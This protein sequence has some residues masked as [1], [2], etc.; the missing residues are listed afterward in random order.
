MTKIKELISK[1][2]L[3]Y[4]VYLGLSI[5]VIGLTGLGY[6]SDNLLF[7]RFLG[8]INLLIAI[9][10]II[11]LGLVLLSFLLSQGWFAIYE[12]ENLKGLLRY[13][14]LATLFGLI[15][16]LV[17][18]LTVVFPA[19]LNMLFPESLLFYPVMGFIVEILF[20]VLPITLILII[21]TLLSEKITN[22]IIW[23]IIFAVSLFEPIFQTILGFSG[24]YPLWTVAYVGLHVFLINLSQLIIFKRYDFISMYSFRLVYYILWHI[25]WGYL[26]LK[27][28]F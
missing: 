7:Q 28:L 26:R 5:G 6:F 9:L 10:F 18:Y 16:I 17:D 12:K 4:L 1:E 15:A 20:H 14:G 11:F 21:L 22:K 27:L 25:V 19:D 3:Q 8:K 13:S 24:Q 2:R 23:V